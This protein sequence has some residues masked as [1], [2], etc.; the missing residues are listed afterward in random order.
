MMQFNTIY[1]NN[2]N[3]ELDQHIVDATSTTSE[4]NTKTA[5]GIPTVDES[6]QSLG[7]INPYIIMNGPCEWFESWSD[8]RVN[9]KD[10]TVYFFLYEVLSVWQ[11]HSRYDCP[12]GIIEQDCTINEF[13]M[14]ERWCTK[15]N[16]RFRIFTNEY[17]MLDA[18]QNTRYAN[19]AIYPLD[20]FSLGYCFLNREYW[21]GLNMDIKYKVNCFTYRWDQHRNLAVSF[22]HKTFGDQ[23]ITHY[24]DTENVIDKYSFNNSK[25][26]KT[27]LQGRKSL[28]NFIPLT[29]DIDKTQKVDMH[30]QKFPSDGTINTI[31]NHSAGIEEYYRNSF[32]TLACETNYEY[33]WGQI[34]EKVLDPM[35]HGSSI[36][37]L[38]GPH[39]LELLK[40]WGLKTFS[41]FWDESY[42]E[43]LNPIT[44]M[45]K[46]FDI[47]L[48]LKQQSLK[49][50]KQIREHMR[51]TLVH[52]RNH[53][54]TGA[55]RK[56]IIKVI[57]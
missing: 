42:D 12:E 5:V 40:H 13:D 25:H 30:T 56:D 18:L 54:R 23:P 48:D 37:L 57:Q 1:I 20:T 4:Y 44:R 11:N 2:I 33:P 35:K 16:C 50:L 31:S 19:W 17:R 39:S 14:I 24:H 36:L 41:E 43:E 32:V 53:I 49:E 51:P 47:L 34:S 6:L 46:V 55:I 45:D 3:K 52:N 28:N 27:L 38:A 10:Q 15:H 26:Y 22:I 9:L 21:D 7:I 29:V 8:S